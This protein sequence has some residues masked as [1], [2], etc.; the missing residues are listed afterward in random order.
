MEN[1]GLVL[2][3]GGMRGLYTTGVLDFFMEKDLYFPYVIG[4]SM[5]ACNGLSYVSRQKGRNK[6]ININY[7]ND[8]RYLSYKNLI[9]K[10]ELFGSEFIFDE[11]PNKLEIFD[12]ETFTK[13]KEK[14]VVAVTDCDK[15][16][17]VYFEKSECKDKDVYDVVKASSSLPFMAP[18]VKFQGLNLL[19]GGVADPIPIKKSIKDGN[20]KNVIILTRNEGYVKKPFKMKFL[21]RK[22]YSQHKGLADAI[23]YRHKKYNSTLNYIEKLEKEGRAFVIRPGEILKVR[24]IEKDK[25]KLI[26][27]YNQGYREAS[28]CYDKLQ[29]WIKQ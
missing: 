25:N 21:A 16:E 7:V 12:I 24:R 2:E 1:I 14:F 8:P 13:A 29:E 6:N 18:V 20:N 26:E 15:G 23:V 4:V 9:I 10:K 5:G 27:L 17:A 11:L 3:G 28:Q 19:D 22:I